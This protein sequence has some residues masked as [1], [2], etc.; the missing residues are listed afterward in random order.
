QPQFNTPPPPPAQPVDADEQDI[1]L[2]TEMVFSGKRRQQLRDQ[3][4]YQTLHTG[5]LSYDDPEDLYDDVTP[6]EEHSTQLHITQDQPD[7]PT[8]VR[9]EPAQTFR[10]YQPPAFDPQQHYSQQTGTTNE[11]FAVTMFVLLVL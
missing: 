7:L 4:A 1:G 6:A 3:Q 5:D 9:Q 2:A 10:N 8:A 11:P